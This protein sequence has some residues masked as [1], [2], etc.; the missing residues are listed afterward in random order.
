[1]EQ[2]F[3][4]T[5][6]IIT[7][8]SFSL[9]FTVFVAASIF[10]KITA[11]KGISSFASFFIHLFFMFGIGHLS[12]IFTG[13]IANSIFR[14]LDSMFIPPLVLLTAFLLLSVT[15]LAAAMNF[16]TYKVSRCDR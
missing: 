15:S 3:F 6:I 11:D 7:I 1:M 9:A 8:C 14:A 2:T 12:Y 13:F 16:W 5:A 4:I 10:S